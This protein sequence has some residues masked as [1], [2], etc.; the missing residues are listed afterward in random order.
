[1]EPLNYQPVTTATPIAATPVAP[2]RG[3]G[4]LITLLILLVVTLGVWGYFM[5]FAPDEYIDDS[6]Y[7]APIQNRNVQ[8]NTTSIEADLEAAGSIDNSDDIKD[9]DSAFQ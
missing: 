6:Q 9:I 5:Y 4:F 1:M 3:H 8:Q 7:V 2:P